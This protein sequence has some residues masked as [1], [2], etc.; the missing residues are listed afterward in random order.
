M[1]GRVYKRGRSWTARFDAPGDGQRRQVSK[2]GFATRAEAQ[3]W[4]RGQLAQ[5]DRGTFAEPSK[6]TVEQYL[7]DEWLP[8]LGGT[9]RPVTFERHR[10]NCTVHLIPA[11]GQIKL[12]ALGPGHVVGLHNR[13]REAG[14]RPNT[15]RAIHNTLS[16]ALTDAHRW[17]RVSTNVARTAGAPPAAPTRVKAWS[18]SEVERFLAVAGDDRL[19]ALWRVIAVTG[20]RRGE[21][22]GL[23]W[24]NVDLDT[25]R[26]AIEQQVG[27][28]R[29]GPDLGPP[30]TGRGRR[31][32]ALDTTTV[33]A[34]RRHRDVQMLERD[35]VGPAYRDHDLIFC[36]E[37]GGPI[38]PASAT[39]ACGRLRRR[40][41]IPSGGMHTLRH[42]AATI[43]LTSG[44][45]VHVVAT[46]LGDD[47][48]TVLRTYAHLIPTSDQQAA[49]VVAAAVTSGEQM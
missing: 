1:T 39:R 28:V 40:A 11:L 12:Q 41:D 45:P 25:G 16:R 20:M 23:T 43:M 26:L 17:S 30:K 37:D 22:L 21:A 13:L 4:L 44:I 5:L 15:V 29:G 14:L 6:L 32:V 42:S 3:R 2:G 8:A 31:T 27:Q 47:P 34:L 18:A 48:A 9:V 35:V 38:H 49:D 24:R 33:Q 7:Q 19:A 46:R 10:T 36:R